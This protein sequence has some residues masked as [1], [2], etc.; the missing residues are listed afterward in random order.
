MCYAQSYPAVIRPTYSLSVTR[1][2][3]VQ[4][5]SMFH[6]QLENVQ[7]FSD[8]A[9]HVFA[10]SPQ[11]CE[12]G[13]PGSCFLHDFWQ[14]AVRHVR[15]LEQ[16]PRFQLHKTVLALP[17]PLLPSSTVRTSE[18]QVWLWNVGI[19]KAAR[20]DRSPRERLEMVCTQFATVSQWPVCA[21]ER[22]SLQ[23]VESWPFSKAH[24]NPTSFEK[25]INKK[26]K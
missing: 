22:R 9:S 5:G 11:T 7:G 6:M 21:R 19:S 12:Q 1:I 18:I 25:T 20:R 13:C 26:L 16:R 14:E 17:I 15:M 23:L 2:T 4:I 3:H 10:S 24:R 8:C